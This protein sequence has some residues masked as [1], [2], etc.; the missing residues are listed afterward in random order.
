MHRIRVRSTS[1]EKTDACDEEKKNI[2]FCFL[3]RLPVKIK[4]QPNH[5]QTNYYHS[6]YI[7]KHPN[8][9]THPKHEIKIHK[10]IQSR[11]AIE[12][13]KQKI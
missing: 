9:Q 12:I 4:Y 6:Q 3:T 10:H 13:V 7:Y 1:H 2:L 5:I 8:P 11:K